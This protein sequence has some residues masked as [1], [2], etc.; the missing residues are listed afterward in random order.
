MSVTPTREDK[1]TFGL[2]TIGWNAQ[3]PFGS[4]T[5]GP[6]DAV[7]AIHKL[8][9]LG[10]YGFEPQ[11]TVLLAALVSEDPLLLIGRSGTGTISAPLERITP[12]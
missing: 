8:S 5:R 4:A 3:D 7:E 2:W 9:E 12:S 11:E 6:L 10:A 1:F